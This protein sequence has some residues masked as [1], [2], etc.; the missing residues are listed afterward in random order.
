MSSFQRQSRASPKTPGSKLDADD[1]VPFPSAMSLR[2]LPT[3]FAAESSP[4][5]S[6]P[7]TPIYYPAFPPQPPAPPKTSQRYIAAL[8]KLVLVPTIFFGLPVWPFLAATCAVPVIGV[9]AIPLL[10]LLSVALLYAIAW[11]AYLFLAQPDLPAAWTSNRRWSIK[12]FAPFLP[13]SPVRCAKVDLAAFRY[14]ITAV[15]IAIPAV[16]DWS[17]RRVMVLGTQKG[18]SVVKE[19]ILYGSPVGGKRLDVYLPPAN[20]SSS[21]DAADEADNA[22]NSLDGERLGTRGRKHSTTFPEPS[23]AA[24]PSSASVAGSQG[25]SHSAGAPVVV[26]VPSVSA[27]L[28]ITSKRK[29]YLQLALR[30]RRMGYCVIVPDIT[31]YPESRIKSSIIDLRLVLRWTGRNCQRYGGDPAKIYV[32]GHGLSAHLVM[33]T[34]AQEAVVLSREGHLDRAYE[35]QKGL[36]RWRENPYGD[37]HDHAAAMG[38]DDEEWKKSGEVGGA[39]RIVSG[40]HTHHPTACAAAFTAGLSLGVNSD[41]DEAEPVHLHYSDRAEASGSA[42]GDAWINEPAGASS[43]SVG[44][45]SGSGPPPGAV[46][47]ATRRFSPAAPDAPGNGRPSTRRAASQRQASPSAHVLTS[48]G[49]LAATA[50][51]GNGLKRVSIYEPEIE[52]PALAGILLFSGISD[53]IKGFRSESEAGLEHLSSLRRATGPSHIQC[54][55]NSP[56]HLLYAAKNIL[57]TRLLP[58][59]VLLVHGG[60]DSVVPIE[61]STLLKTLLVGVGVKEVKLRAYRHLGHAESL[62]CLF[63]GMGKRS[64]RYAR[65]VAE[66]VRNFIAQ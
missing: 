35:R 63:L 47:G 13:L 4:S 22:R 26:V 43:S 27:P 49:Y 39:G 21:Y 30:L 12:N 64:G 34:V 5:P 50:E 33:L 54:L 58:P 65:Q 62:A 28:S 2:K 56:A 24:G 60:K 40:H 51:V 37:C 32:L 19:G 48:P 6:P 55:L 57:D 61:Q 8:L 9:M 20:L 29:L 38:D 31:Y 16:F 59:K 46:M 44:G 53:V 42:G 7:A 14:A 18:A 66:D 23:A 1:P 10:I 41:E 36:E 25:S 3:R 52:M 15:R 45:G 17:Y 11:L